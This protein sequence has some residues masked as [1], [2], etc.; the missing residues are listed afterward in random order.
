MKLKRPLTW[1]AAA[2]RFVGDAAA[3]A[4]RGRKARSPEYDFELVLKK[5]GLV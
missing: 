1:D 5:A 3:N 4:L 2:E